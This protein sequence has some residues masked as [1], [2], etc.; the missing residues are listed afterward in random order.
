[1]GRLQQAVKLVLR[2]QASQTRTQRGGELQRKA[3][4]WVT[5]LKREARASE[6]RL[7][8]GRPQILG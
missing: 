7:Y 3:Y 1:M 6:R 5:G 4:V 8:T 2:E